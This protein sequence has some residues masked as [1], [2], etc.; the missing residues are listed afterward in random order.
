MLSL[1]VFEQMFFNGCE[2]KWFFA[3]DAIIIHGLSIMHYI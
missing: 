1:N 2:I 3:S